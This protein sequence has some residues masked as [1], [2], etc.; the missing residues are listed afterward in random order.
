MGTHRDADP[1][2]KGPKQQETAGEKTR[3]E[4]FDYQ[5]LRGI[6]G[7]ANPKRRKLRKSRTRQEVGPWGRRASHHTC[8]QSTVLYKRTNESRRQRAEREFNCG[9]AGL[10]KFLYVA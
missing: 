8:P 2:G 10:W 1:F 6:Q 5:V 4:S 7:G 3:Q 9:A